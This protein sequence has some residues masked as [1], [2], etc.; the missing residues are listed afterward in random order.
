MKGIH[1]CRNIH[2]YSELIYISVN[3]FSEL[4]QVKK[5]AQI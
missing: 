2:I 4:E 3:G 1:T 5:I